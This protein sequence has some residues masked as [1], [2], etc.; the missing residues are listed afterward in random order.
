ME[1]MPGGLNL[2][3]LCP[4]SPITISKPDIS[5]T[6]L[7]PPCRNTESCP[8]NSLGYLNKEYSELVLTSRSC[9]LVS[10]SSLE[11]LLQL[12]LLSEFV[13]TI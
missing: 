9:V 1:N 12:T 4:P 7:F 13:T 2:R 8:T 6:A 10:K 5:L 3:R 11:A